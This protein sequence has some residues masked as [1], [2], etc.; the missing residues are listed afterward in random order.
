MDPILIMQSK[1]ADLVRAIYETEYYVDAFERVCDHPSTLH[2]N[3]KRFQILNQFWVS[4]P[5]SRQIRTPVFFQLCDIL[6]NEPEP[7]CDE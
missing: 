4:L 1:I 6:E 2:I 3:P 7:D 5:D